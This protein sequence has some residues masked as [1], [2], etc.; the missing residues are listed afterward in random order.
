M[1]SLIPAS[2]TQR[3]KDLDKVAEFSRSRLY[4]QLQNSF[5]LD[6]MRCDVRFLDALATFYSVQ[7]FGNVLSEQGKREFIRD[8]ILIKK[9]RG[10]LWAVKRAVNALDNTLVIEEGMLGFPLD[11]SVLLSGSGRLGGN[12]GAFVLNLTSGTSINT[13]TGKKIINIVGSVS[14]ART[15]LLLHHAG[16]P[17]D[18]SAKGDGSYT[19][20]E[21]NAF[22]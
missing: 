6:P 12:I 18:G 22:S 16:L 17:L 5:F 2:Y 10:T 4:N 13:A 19:L 7:F 3:E 8:S 20:G 1:D 9:R 15:Q 21:M 14:P 11:G